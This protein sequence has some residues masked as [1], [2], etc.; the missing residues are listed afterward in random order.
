MI[1]AITPVVSSKELVQRFTEARATLETELYK[2]LRRTAEQAERYAKGTTLFR[3]RTNAL[4]NS[5]EST[6]FGRYGG[7]PAAQ[8]AAN[9]PHAG[10]M[11][12]G[13]KGHPV[14][15]KRSKVL[16]WV[17]NGQAKFSKGHWVRGITPRPFMANAKDR[18]TPLFEELVAEA[19]VRAFA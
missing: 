15:P 9:A 16:A 3:H 5:I 11:E 19:F 13:T 6:V 7:N 12:Y 2:A 18:V 10:F 17:E 14:T 8:V 4:R 1:P